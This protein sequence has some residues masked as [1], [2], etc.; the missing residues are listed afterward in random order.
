MRVDTM[1]RLAAANPVATAPTVESPERLR[2]LIEDDARALDLNE[3]EGSSTTS[4]G[5]RKASRLR[6]R[7]LLAVPVCVAASVAGVLLTSGSSGPGVNVAAAAYAATSPRR[8]V[9]EAV[10]LAR[11]FEGSE[12]GASL[13]QREWI[14]SSKGLRRKQYS[15]TGPYGD[16]AERHVLESVTAPGRWEN[17]SAGPERNV[18]TRVR[19]PDDVKMNLA[20]DGISLTGVEGIGL[21]RQLYRLGGMKLVGRERHNGRLLWKLESRSIAGGRRL[22]VATRTKRDVLTVA[23]HA[24]LVVLVD[25]KTFL[26]VFE[27]QIDVA[28]AGHPVVVENDLLSYRHYAGGESEGRLFDLALQHPSASV[29]TSNDR[30]PKFVPQ[31]KQARSPK[32]R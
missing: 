7:A 26:P 28:Q 3:R 10:F 13:R 17:W 12:A 2:R 20:F 29:H 25:P 1:T 14:D 23:T 16:R 31:H 6:R 19:V 21:Y 32:R 18:V 27:R 24:R 9:V 8:G 30:F 11:V 5:L 15:T 22:T 4:K